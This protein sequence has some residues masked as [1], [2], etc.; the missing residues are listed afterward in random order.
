MSDI[1]NELEE[2]ASEDEI[3]ARTSIAVLGQIAL[4]VPVEYCRLIIKI[5]IK[6]VQLEREHICNEA[7]LVFQQLL[8]KFPGEFSLIS[9]ALDTLV[10]QVTDNTSKCSLLL[11][12]GEFG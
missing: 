9:V 3:V 6:K 7:V 4:R 5:L 1:F 11:I 10:Q 2:Y 8:R 12:L